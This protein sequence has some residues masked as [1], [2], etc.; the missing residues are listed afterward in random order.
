MTRRLLKLLIALLAMLFPAWF[1]ALFCLA[2]GSD[3]RGA[4]YVIAFVVWFSVGFWIYSRK[5]TSMRAGCCRACGY[6]LTGNVSDVCPEC[7]RIIKR[8]IQSTDF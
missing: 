3:L 5:N 7:G 6:D 4:A 1:V 8:V 2:F